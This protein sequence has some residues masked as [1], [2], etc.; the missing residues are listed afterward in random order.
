MVITVQYAD[1]T[2]R[3]SLLEQ[4][5]D[6]YLIIEKNIREGSFL[7]FTDERPVT[8]QIQTLESAIMELSVLVAGGAGNV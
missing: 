4:Y 8:E 6:K 5:Q 1:L 2:E 7:I 3:E